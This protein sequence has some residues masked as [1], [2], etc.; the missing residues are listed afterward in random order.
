MKS[1]KKEAPPRI[2]DGVVSEEQNNSTGITLL[3]SFNWETLNYD[4]YL[5]A[6]NSQFP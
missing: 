3:E 4:A 5:D 2:I 6:K 1:S